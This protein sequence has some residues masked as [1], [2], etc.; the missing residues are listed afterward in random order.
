[1]FFN[2]EGAMTFY[3]SMRNLD[4]SFIVAEKRIGIITKRPLP[5]AL[6]DKI[7]HTVNF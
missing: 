1:V 5:S 4:Q 7:Q 6:I 2:L 3:A